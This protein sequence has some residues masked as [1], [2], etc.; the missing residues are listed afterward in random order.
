MYCSLAGRLELVWEF[1]HFYLW[2]LD[3]FGFLGAARVFLGCAIPGHR[4]A[5]YGRRGSC[6]AGD[7]S[8]WNRILGD[9]NVVGSLLGASGRI[10]VVAVVLAI[11]VGGRTFVAVRVVVG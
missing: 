10:K 8:F 11:G 9:S 1:V 5:R 4:L 7:S 2:L 3:R 6:L